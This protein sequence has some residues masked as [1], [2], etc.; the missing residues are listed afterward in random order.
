MPEMSAA[1]S[2][3]ST[4]GGRRVQADAEHGVDLSDRRVG[5]RAHRFGIRAG[6]GVNARRRRGPSGLGWVGSIRSLLFS[7]VIVE[8]VMVCRS[9]SRPAFRPICSEPVDSTHPDTQG[10]TFIVTG[11]PIRATAAAGNGRLRRQF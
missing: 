6:L 2:D 11:R 1:Q 4:S 10:L 9:L 3:S 8:L 5:Q 7:E